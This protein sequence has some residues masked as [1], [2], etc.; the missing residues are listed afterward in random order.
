M[1]TL[2]HNSIVNSLSDTYICSPPER[3]SSYVIQN[4]FCHFHITSSKLKKK[5]TWCPLHSSVNFLML[6]KM[7]W[8]FPTLD[9]P[10]SHQTKL[11]CRCACRRPVFIA[12]LTITHFILWLVT[13][14]VPSHYLNQCWN[15]A[16]WTL[17]NKLQ[18]NFDKNSYIFI[19]ENAFENFCKTAAILSWPRCVTAL[20]LL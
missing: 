2:T 7:T 10:I 18:W 5:C 14:S 4:D 3:I 20:E 12:K 6:T 17:R 1:V 9:I 13:W 16:N 19:Q 15:I 11:I 8:N